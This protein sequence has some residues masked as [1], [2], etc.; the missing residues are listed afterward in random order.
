MELDVKNLRFAVISGGIS[1]EREVCL[2]E[3]EEIY[4]L[5]KSIDLNVKHIIVDNNLDK[6]CEEI[7]NNKFDFAFISLTEDLPIQDLLE[8]L[9][10]PYNGSPRMPTAIS[11]DKILTKI[12]VKGLDIL[13]PNYCYMKHISDMELFMENASKLRFPVVVKPGNLGTSIGI[14]FVNSYEQLRSAV[15][16]SL[17]YSN[18]IIAEEFIDG[19]EVTIP[20]MGDDFVGIV[21]I[22]PEKTLYDNDS[23]MNNLRK[24][25]CPSNLPVN[26]QNDLLEKAK[27]IYKSMG[28]KGLARIDGIVV[29]DR[30]YFL[31]LNTLPFMVGTDAPIQVANKLYNL[32]KLQFLFSIIRN[33]L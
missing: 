12:I 1:P 10:I 33:K 24:Q 30:F 6:A 21:E 3:G 16:K 20:I 11:I 29:A 4:K 25:I 13:T 8:T 5:F 9:H 32:D 19:T 17:E 31:E 23:K 18:Y 14:Y 28:C 27:T 15:E 26:L 7:I 2:M 22:H